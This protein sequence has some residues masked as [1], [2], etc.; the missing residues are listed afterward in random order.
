MFQIGKELPIILKHPQMYMS[1]HLVSSSV[2]GSANL[3]KHLSNIALTTARPDRDPQ[4]PKCKPLL[5]STALMP[6]AG[7]IHKRY[8]LCMSSSV[9]TANAYLVP[10]CGPTIA[11]ISLFPKPGGLTL[12]RH[13]DCDVRLP[14]E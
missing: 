9:D 5:L 2:P 8:S 7:A 13:V 14:S 6:I 1:S 3:C 12:G 10:I 11:P 4:I